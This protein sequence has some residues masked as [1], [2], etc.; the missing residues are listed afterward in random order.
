MPAPIYYSKGLIGLDSGV[1]KTWDGK[2]VHP[3]NVLVINDPNSYDC[4]DESGAK[5]IEMEAEFEK[6]IR[7]VSV[8]DDTTGLPAIDDFLGE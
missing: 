7:T 1:M 8:S 4:Y 6:I 3:Q 2:L 5:L